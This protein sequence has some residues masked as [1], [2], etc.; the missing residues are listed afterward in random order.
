MA[1]RSSQITGIPSGP[2][3]RR[4]DILY[5]LAPCRRRTVRE[6][7][8]NYP[9]DAA[10]FSGLLKC[11]ND[12]VHLPGLHAR[13]SKTKVAPCVSSSQ[14]V[15]RVVSIMVRQRQEEFPPQSRG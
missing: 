6:F 5:G 7:S 15:P 8:K 10:K 11:I 1:N 13:S 14:G 4:A 12:T 2:R 3:I 9:G